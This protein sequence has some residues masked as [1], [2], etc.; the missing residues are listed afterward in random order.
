MPLS[1]DAVLEGA[2]ASDI[3]YMSQI[4]SGGPVELP[5]NALQLL[6][7]KGWIDV[8]SETVLI[9][10]TGRTLIERSQLEAA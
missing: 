7:M 6:A 2:T 10:L 5:A 3:K 8:Y 1:K 9:T 4:W